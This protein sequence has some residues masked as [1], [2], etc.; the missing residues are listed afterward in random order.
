MKTLQKG[1]I[2]LGLSLLC[3]VFLATEITAAERFCTQDGPI[4]ALIVGCPPCLSFDPDLVAQFHQGEQNQQFFDCDTG[5]PL[6]ASIIAAEHILRS[7]Q[8][9]DRGTQP[10][11][12]ACFA[13][14]SDVLP[15]TILRVAIEIAGVPILVEATGTTIV[16]R[17]GDGP[18]PGP[19]TIEMDNTTLTGQTDLGQPVTVRIGQSFGLPPT[20]GTVTRVPS[21]GFPDRVAVAFAINAGITLEC[22]PTGPVEIGCNDGL[23]GDCDGLID[24]DDPD[25]VPLVVTLE[26]FIAERTPVGV[27]LRWSTSSEEGNLGFRILRGLGFNRSGSVADLD[28]ISLGII[29]TQGTA[30]FGAQYEFIDV[31]VRKSGVV[32]YYLE[33]IDTQ[34]VVT[35]HGPVVVD[36]GQGLKPGKR[37]GR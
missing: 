24:G 35:R 3:L 22:Q 31:L 30:L 15:D 33:D 32:H 11:P 37:T 21:P 26:S 27:R 5:L 36:F 1:L 13:P 25:C 12:E 29:P 8:S 6:P 23:D 20:L 18:D 16:E 9:G 7:C 28:Q 17:H 2:A 10:T 19:A 4:T 34:G 14:G